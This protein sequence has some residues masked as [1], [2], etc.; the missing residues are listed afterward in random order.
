[1]KKDKMGEINKLDRERTNAWVLSLSALLPMK[2]ESKFLN[3][4]KGTL[5]GYGKEATPEARKSPAVSVF[6]LHT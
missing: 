2:W 4:V 3:N 1:M 6:S 5:D